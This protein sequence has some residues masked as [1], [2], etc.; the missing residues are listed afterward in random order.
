MLCWTWF[1]PAR[2]DSWEMWTS[3]AAELHW[4]W[5]GRVWD[6][7]GS[8]KSAQQSSVPWSSG[9]LTSRDLLGRVPWDKALEGR[10]A[11]DSWLI[12]KD[13]LLQ[14]Q[15]WCLPTKRKLCK[16][17]RRPVWINKLI[18][19]KL[20]H[21]REACREWKQSKVAWE[22]YREM[23]QPGIRLGKLKLWENSTWPGTRTTR[24]AS[25]HIWDR[26]YRS[27]YKHLNLIWNKEC[28]SVR[29][30]RLEGDWACNP[31][32]FSYFVSWSG[33]TLSSFPEEGCI[34]YYYRQYYRI[35]YIYIVYI[36]L[37]YWWAVIVRVAVLNSDVDVWNQSLVLKVTVIW[38]NKNY[39]KGEQPLNNWIFSWCW[40]V[41]KDSFG[42]DVLIFSWL[43][44]N[45]CKSVYSFWSDQGK[46]SK[47][48]TYSPVWQQ[49]SVYVEKSLP[50]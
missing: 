44:N 49:C 41:Y 31:S 46:L 10:G 12:L 47:V 20:K 45:P 9:E 17:I 22:N 50:S 27:P 1:S 21:K 5:S 30:C 6:P 32:T 36:I 33:K 2:R 26:I 16:H 29:Q 8:K 7:M 15:A 48:Q 40:H 3:K 38:Y 42:D 24:K 11:Q 28:M 43:R 35:L 34:A 37:Y 25:V 14:T 39:G 23:E 19:D 13:R 4:Q 18:V